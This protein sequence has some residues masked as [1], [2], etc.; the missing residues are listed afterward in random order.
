MTLSIRSRL[1]L[2]AAVQLLVLLLM[3]GTGV[4]FSQ[5]VV[6]A[7]AM[8]EGARQ[9]DA[10][11]QQTLRSAGE[12][13]LT[14]GAS[15]SKD[16][17][18]AALEQVDTRLTELKA[19]AA[20]SGAVL[21]IDAQLGATWPTVR[22]TVDQMRTNKKLSIDDVDV[23]VAFGK[24]V[25]KGTDLTKSVDLIVTE[26]QMIEDQAKSSLIS[27]VLVG[28]VL[29]VITNFITSRLL[30]KAVNAP[31]SAAI[32][33]AERIGAGYIAN[34]IDLSRDDEMGRLMAALSKMQASL[35][36]MVQSIAAVSEHIGA[37]A[38]EFATGNTHLAQRTEQQASNVQQTSA[39]LRELTET[40]AQSSAK[41][42]QANEMT[43][44]SAA[45]AV[46]GGE[47]VK[48]VAHTIG[49]IVASSQKMAAII[50]V[51]DGIAFQ[52]NILALNAAVEA[53]RAGEQGRG[54][55]VVASEVRSLA[56]RSAAAA[57]E[58]KALIDD[59]VQ[60][61]QQGNAQANQAGEKMEQLVTSFSSMS[62]L[63]AQIAHAT[64]EQN[65]GLSNI[66]HAVSQVD[67]M[68]QQ[69]AALV[70]QSTAS[71]DELRVQAGK[72][73]Q[74]THAFSMD[75]VPVT[76]RQARLAAS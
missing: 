59:S 47:A 57:K 20:A 34:E 8:K 31:L 44:Q 36:S 24:M 27:V 29:L 11:V 52:T 72:L 23:M 73:M 3:V 21:D 35:Q 22:A 12:L 43:R 54:F 48:R 45:A 28:L 39:S 62:E 64:H 65:D 55:A 14:E 17:A 19:Q 7:M 67:D 66:N 75:R 1:I 58:I 53:A 13:L 37:A 70:E 40:V 49:E 10:G 2:S 68:T 42:Q 4:H 69:N 33:I 74:A 61:V 38:N 18:K 30:F 15:S 51:I 9:L 26:T 71:A 63:I 6:A 50:G 41:V 60:R 32:G 25:T 46:D 16:L 56:G 5:R 76:S